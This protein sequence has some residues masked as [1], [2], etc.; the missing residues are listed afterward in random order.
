M[1]VK[2][3]GDSYG[4]ENEIVNLERKGFEPLSS[5]TPENLCL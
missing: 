5:T 2:I 1:E 4:S 3:V